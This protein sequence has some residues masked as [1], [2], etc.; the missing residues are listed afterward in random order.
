MALRR[1]AVLLRKQVAKLDADGLPVAGGSHLD[2]GSLSEKSI[3][4][5]LQA[6]NEGA[7]EL[8]SR[9]PALKTDLSRAEKLLPPRRGEVQERRGMGAAAEETNMR[10]AIALA[11]R[12]LEA[13]ERYE[14]V[15]E[16]S[17]DQEVPEDDLLRPV[18]A[19]LGRCGYCSTADPK[20]FRQG[21]VTVNRRHVRD[22][23]MLVSP[24]DD[25]SVGSHRALV[26]YP[27]IYRAYKSPGFSFQMGQSPDTY[28]DRRI[29]GLPT[30]CYSICGNL[31]S[32]AKGL[33][34]F[35]NDQSLAV[36]MSKSHDV[37]RDWEVSVVGS[38]HPDMVR[39]FNKAF[40]FE[41]KFY[42]NVEVVVKSLVFAS[43]HYKK[44]RDRNIL[45][46]NLAVRTWG[47]GPNIPRLFANAGRRVTDL[48]RVKIGPYNVEALQPERAIEAF[49]DEGLMQHTG[50]EWIPWIDFHAPLLARG[51]ASRLQ[52]YVNIRRNGAQGAEQLAADLEKMREDVLEKARHSRRSHLHQ[53]ELKVEDHL[54]KEADE[55]YAAKKRKRKLGRGMPRTATRSPSDMLAD[56]GNEP[57]MTGMT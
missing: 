18:K 24:Q 11:T 44:G 46:T 52:R 21:L 8:L 56:L 13:E 29:K 15:R 57:I 4:G 22:P 33:E 51:L 34:L 1:C 35:T 31:S 50:K 12:N 10:R 23:N 27:R 40:E 17:K 7:D 30:F 14:I 25:V 48:R 5:R 3:Y 26:D 47:P 19:V 54:S 43:K 39:G 20:H 16:M 37:E 49:I 32:S 45:Q 42:S 6:K 53:P 38:V 55:S 36:Y 2:D 41:G 28:D 9:V